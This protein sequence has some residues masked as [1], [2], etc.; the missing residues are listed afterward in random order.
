[1]KIKKPNAILYFLAYILAYPVL[2]FCFRLK[3]VDKDLK[4]PKGPYIIMSNHHTMIDFLMVMLSFYPRRL[5]AVGAQKW[6]LYKP[7]HKL[8]P[9]MGV[10]PK[11]MFDPDIRS[12]IGI[13]TVVN[14]GDGIL[15]F[16]EGRCS[17]S[18]AYVGMHKST[19]KL[20]KKFGVP[21]ISAYIEGANVC[22]PH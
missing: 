16:P 17:S 13:K 11:N 6:Y 1:M 2:K 18:N 5:N 9:M 15:L 4:M 14:R 12:I 20:I 22:M 3:V 10:I 8:L 21:V 19:G 7:L